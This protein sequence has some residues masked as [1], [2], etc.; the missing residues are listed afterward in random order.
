MMEGPRGRLVRPTSAM[1]LNRTDENLR[2]GTTFSGRTSP[3]SRVDFKGGRPHSAMASTAHTEKFASWHVSTDDNRSAASTRSTS[4]VGDYSSGA[5][6][7][8]RPGSSKSARSWHQ[9]SL[10]SPK[11]IGLPVAEQEDGEMTKWTKRRYVYGTTMENFTHLRK[12]G[13]Y[14]RLLSSTERNSKLG[15][16]HDAGHHRQSTILSCLPLARPLKTFPLIQK[17]TMYVPVL[18]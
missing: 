5:S 9:H 13:M 17:F 12:E 3:S 18:R 15:K 6:M 4:V 8:E 14:R 11:S 2:L 1:P 7:R 16:S 10:T